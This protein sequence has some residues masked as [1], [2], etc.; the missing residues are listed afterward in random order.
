MED[1]AE[2]IKRWG[3]EERGAGLKVKEQ[4]IKNITPSSRTCYKESRLAQLYS[5]SQLDA[6][7][8]LD[9]RHLRHTRPSP[10]CAVNWIIVTDA[11]SQPHSVV[12]V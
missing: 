3:W 7:V 12:L 1:I 4:K 2:E 8:T 5:Q 9:T 6:P 10:T 11:Q